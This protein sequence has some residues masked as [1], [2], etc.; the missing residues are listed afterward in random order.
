MPGR[1]GSAPGSLHPSLPPSCHGSAPAPD[2]SHPAPSLPAA[3]RAFC[4][5]CSS[6]QDHLTRRVYCGAQTLAPAIHAFS[7]PGLIRPLNARHRYFVSTRC[8]P[9][10]RDP[11]IQATPGAT[12]ILASSP[13]ARPDGSRAA[14]SRSRKLL[15]QQYRRLVTRASYRSRRRHACDQGY[16]SS[17]AAVAAALPRRLPDRARRPDHGSAR[18]G[19]A[20]I[21]GRREPADWTRGAAAIR[22][23]AE[24]SGIV[25]VLVPVRHPAPPIAV[26]S[27]FTARGECQRRSSGSR[28]SVS[29]R[30]REP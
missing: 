27:A 1:R 29:L 24:A 8:E 4:E 2:A 3:K 14:Q 25:D 18:H 13:G 20:A 26:M 12:P 16:G 7:A 15:D 30:S 17:R 21:R 23:P 22:H 9:G 6:V 10:S 19:R 11:R 28:Q 5:H